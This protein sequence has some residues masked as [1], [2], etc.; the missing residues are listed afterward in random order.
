M[1]NNQH[2]EEIILNPKLREQDPRFVNFLK[3]VLPKNIY[4]TGSTINGALFLEPT[5]P[6]VLT[7]IELILKEIHKWA[8][9]PSSFQVLNNFQPL[10]SLGALNKTNEIKEKEL[11]KVDIIL[12]KD[13]QNPSGKYNLLPGKYEFPFEIKLPQ[14]MSPS[15]FYNNPI[16]SVSCYI[17]HSLVTKIYNGIN[18]SDSDIKFL[19][20][21]ELI[22]QLP[23]NIEVDRPL[24]VEIKHEVNSLGFFFTSGT[25]T[26]KAQLDQGIYSYCNDIIFNVE[27][28]NRNCTS[29]IT[30]I[31]CDVKR[32]LKYLNSPNINRLNDNKT[33]TMDN[34][35]E[36]NLASKITSFFSDE[37]NPNEEIGFKD[38]IFS[39]VFSLSVKEKSF[40]K[41]AFRFNLTNDLRKEWDN[42][43]ISQLKNTIYKDFCDK[44]SFTS[45]SILMGNLFKCEYKVQ[46]SL[47]Y[48]GLGKDEGKIMKIPLFLSN[49]PY[50][51]QSIVADGV[52]LYPGRSILSKAVNANDDELNS[53]NKKN[54]APPIA[55]DSIKK[56][57]K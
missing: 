25:N 36:F 43:Y 8:S 53:K 57:E 50:L 17:R 19:D 32:C 51:F 31:H 5:Q 49:N 30:G 56:N 29:E 47:I 13:E 2:L 33:S 42:N 3:V 34:E 11:C 20:N 16:T 1:G 4:S 24:P 9:P 15:F 21:T 14:I 52:Y 12:G 48:N 45:P 54:N 6:L 26:M 41:G 38:N 10:I 46:L 7:K 22:I 27:I 40:Y 18:N 44:I 28:D 23:D 37:E 39:T 55:F 35:K